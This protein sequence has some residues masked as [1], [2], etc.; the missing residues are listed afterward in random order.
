MP[1]ILE[2]HDLIGIAET[3]KGK[4]AAFAIPIIQQLTNHYSN[5]NER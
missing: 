5:V 4:T 1:I 3:G 2:A